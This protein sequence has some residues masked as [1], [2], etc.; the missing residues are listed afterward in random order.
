M[1]ALESYYRLS[2][3]IYKILISGPQQIYPPFPGSG[4]TNRQTNRKG[5]YG[6][7]KISGFFLAC[8]IL[9]VMSWDYLWLLDAKLFANFDP[10]FCGSCMFQMNMKP[11]FMRGP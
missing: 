9:M 7:F 11:G 5:I 6:I 2:F 10:E 3:T 1:L 4:W 8:R